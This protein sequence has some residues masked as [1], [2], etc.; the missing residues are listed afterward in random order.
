MEKIGAR[1]FKVLP[2]G[3]PFPDYVFEDEYCMDDLETTKDLTTHF[4]HLPGVMS[5]ED[6]VKGNGYDIELLQ[7][8]M[9]EKIEELYLHIFKL[10][11]EINQLK[12]K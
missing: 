1:S 12:S 10:Q 6:V 3:I 5:K 7:L 11:K 8:Q 4:G 9:L 2:N